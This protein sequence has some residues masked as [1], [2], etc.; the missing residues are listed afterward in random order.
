MKRFIICSA[1][2]LWSSGVLA[3]TANTQDTSLFARYDSNGDACIDAT[4][5]AA[6]AA[7]QRSPNNPTG[8]QQLPS[9]ADFDSD[10]DGFITEAE[11]NAGRAKRI[12]ER[13]AAGKPLRNV[14]NAEPFAAIDTNQDGKIDPT[15]FAEHQRN[16]QRSNP[17]N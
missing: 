13:A 4:E 2:A 11:L 1:L 14:G 17:K 10:Q 8:Q 16:E 15:E 5:F 12:S 7:T 6:F 9:F 3:E